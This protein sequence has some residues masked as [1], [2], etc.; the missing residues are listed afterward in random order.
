MLTMAMCLSIV[1]SILSILGSGWLAAT[2]IQVLDTNR[3][4]CTAVVDML[5]LFCGI[6]IPGYP[7][8]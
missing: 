5:L 2:L 7:S 4:G 8:I 1:I 6:V 3:S